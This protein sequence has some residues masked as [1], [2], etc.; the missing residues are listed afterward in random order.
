MLEAAGAVD[1]HRA[2]NVL[3]G[4]RNL[5][6]RPTTSCRER[7]EV[8]EPHPFRGDGRAQALLGSQES[9]IARRIWGT[10]EACPC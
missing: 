9:L 4:R 5:S 6:G 1:D 2:Q 10:S 3:N 8:L 7:F